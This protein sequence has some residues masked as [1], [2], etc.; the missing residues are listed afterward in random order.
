[1]AV[2]DVVR[3]AEDTG[4]DG[5]CRHAARNRR[6]DA[7]HQQCQRKHHAGAAAQQRVQ[8]RLRLL[9]LLH[10]N[11]AFEES[12]GGQQNHRTVNGP[13]HNHGEERVEQFVLQHPADRGIVL[14]VVL[15]ALY[16][17]RMEKQVMGHHHGSEHTHDNEHTSLRERRSHPPLHRHRPVYPDKEK[18]VDERKPYDGHESNDGPFNLLVGVGEKHYGHENRSQHRT[19]YYGDVQQ[20]LQCDGPAQYFGKGS[21]YGSQHRRTQYRARHPFGSVL[22][23]GFRQAQSRHDAQVRHVV[24]QDYQHDGRERHHPQQRVAE[25]RPR[26]KIRRPVA[27]V[28]E[29]YRHQ[30]SRSDISEHVQTTQIAFVVFP[31]Q[32]FKNILHYYV[33]LVLRM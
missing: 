20:H 29:T 5:T 10:L 14:L 22:R 1:M 28:D 15:V 31:L 7:R 19:P 2:P 9:Q 24:L 11:P 32:V 18:F 8:Q 23:G 16:H 27:G 26:R 12:G 30:Q 33:V 17:L 25:L 3:L 13:S 6:G 4:K 21:G